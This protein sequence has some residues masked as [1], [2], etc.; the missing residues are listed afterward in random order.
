[1]RKI[2][3]LILILLISSQIVYSEFNLNVIP[4]NNESEENILFLENIIKA[5]NYIYKILNKQRPYYSKPDSR[6]DGILK[7]N[8]LIERDLMVLFDETINESFFINLNKEIY[9]EKNVFIYGTPEMINERIP[10]KIYNPKNE[11]KY[12]NSKNENE[13]RYLGVNFLGERVSN[14]D[15]PY[16]IKPSGIEGEELNNKNWIES[17]WKDDRVKNEYPDVSETGF[18]LINVQE[19]NSEMIE[20]IVDE[21]LIS[22]EKEHGNYFKLYGD[23]INEYGIDKSG[24]YLVDEINTQKR[25]EQRE[26][27]IKYIHVTTPFS[28]ISSGASRLW[29]EAEDKKLWY[30]NVTLNRE[31]EEETENEL[32]INILHIKYNDNQ[33]IKEETITLKE[34]TI[35]IEKIENDELK[36]IG[37]QTLKKGE[38]KPFEI[39]TANKSEEITIKKTDYNNE[40]EITIE[41]YYNEEKEIEETEGQL[42]SATGEYDALIA[43]PTNEELKGIIK[44]KEYLINEKINQKE[45][46]I[47][48]TVEVKKTYNYKIWDEKDKKIYKK[49]EEGNYLLDEEGRKIIDHYEG[50]YDNKNKTITNTY[51]IKRTATYHKID[52]FEPYKIKNITIENELLNN[53]KITITPD[54]YNVEIEIEKYNTNIV[55]IPEAVEKIEL[56]TENIGTNKPPTETEVKEEFRTYA[57]KAIGEITIKNDKLKINGQTILD[58][59]PTLKTAPIPN[60]IAESK[61]KEIKSINQLIK[62][63]EENKE[64]TSTGKITYTLISDKTINQINNEEIEKEIE[65]N[66]VK[67]HTPIVTNLLLKAKDEYN[68]EKEAKEDERIM[69]LGME[70]TIRYDTTL[71]HSDKKGYGEKNYDKYIQKKEIKFPFDIYYDTTK[72]DNNKFY[73]KNTWITVTKKDTNIYIPTW[74]DEGEYKIESK[75]TA[76]NSTETLNKETETSNQE[77]TEYIVTD[78]M[79]VKIIGRLYGLRI[80]DISDYPTWEEVFR[81]KEGSYTHKEGIYYPVGHNDENGEKNRNNPKYLLPIIPGSHPIYSN[82]G[83]IKTGYNIKYEITTIGNYT[84]DDKIKI[85][86]TFKYVDEKGKTNKEINLW[87]LVEIKDKNYLI[88]L[89]NIENEEIENELKYIIEVGDPYRDITEKEYE[90]VANTLGITKYELKTKK[91]E[92]GYADKIELNKYLRMYIGDTTDL[93]EGVEETKALKS[94]QKWHGE[95]KLPNNTYV[96]EDKEIDLIEYAIKNGGID[97]T[98]NIFKKDGYILINFEIETIKDKESKGNELNYKSNLSNMYEIEGFNKQKICNTK[99]GEKIFDFE[100]GD[101]I[102]F[103]PTE[104]K[105]DDYKSFGTH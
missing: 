21:F 9:Q 61:I 85:T 99:E 53:N 8:E 22:M 12:K 55:Q 68:Q 24:N 1:M 100:Y 41:I 34:E 6:E 78:K 70:G 32:K 37:Y 43:I 89:N 54:N 62:K 56:E 105:S 91:V 13:W 44:A 95:Y 10:Q 93:P 47:K 79:E 58:D 75:T 69:I 16:D 29:H 18:D 46:T 65:I 51:E 25:N 11:I 36:Y 103:S 28:N 50:G 60:E 64:Y 4:D 97:F 38:E 14:L 77:P 82:V 40:T 66:T 7:M 20:E 52:N 23:E 39:E 80:T 5:E 31:I 27:I 3:C 81:E 90:D 88:N 96:V 87:S 74:I 35:K 48:Y 59:T 15:Y 73:K 71:K 101:I 83:N 92:I 17:P 45:E 42:I 26:N 49:D 33:I 86:P 19:N 102:F 98:E 94:V 104:K 30:I 84:K 72:K 57:E 2:I 76:I 63:E 67:I